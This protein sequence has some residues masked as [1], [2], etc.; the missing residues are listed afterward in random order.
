M[1]LIDRVVVS[2]HSPTAAFPGV[3]AR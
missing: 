1:L 2:I 3:G